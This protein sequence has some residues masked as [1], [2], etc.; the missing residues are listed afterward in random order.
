M[1]WT[2][3][4]CYSEWFLP[5]QCTI[6]N[7]VLWMG[8]LLFLFALTLQFVVGISENPRH[9]EVLI[10]T[11]SLVYVQMPQ[12]LWMREVCLLFI[13][14]EAWE[15]V[16][17][18]LCMICTFVFSM[19][20]PLGF[21]T[22]HLLLVVG[23]IVYY[24]LTH[25]DVAVLANNKNKLTWDSEKFSLLLDCCF[26]FVYCMFYF[27]Q[28]PYVTYIVLFLSALFSL[29]VYFYDEG[30]DRI[31]RISVT[32]VRIGFYL[33]SFFFIYFRV[34]FLFRFL[35]TTLRPRTPPPVAPQQTKDDEEDDEEQ[36]PMKPSPP[37]P[38]PPP[39]IPWSYYLFLLFGVVL[40]CILIGF[41]QTEG[42]VLSYGLL[43]TIASSQLIY[44]NS[45]E[46]IKEGLFFILDVGL[47]WCVQIPLFYTGNSFVWVFIIP[48]IVSFVFFYFEPQVVYVINQ[49]D[50]TVELL[51]RYVAIRGFL[52][53]LVLSFGTFWFI[54]A[55]VLSIFYS[56]ELE[57]IIYRE[58]Y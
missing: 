5:G 13:I 55:C 32:N 37:P 26:T 27:Y 54:T 31:K 36:T 23:V 14:T 22:F 28:T 46:K 7:W 8:V 52:F 11:F 43:L 1:G 15:R 34:G 49:E 6:P 38:P 53:G 33:L 16:L 18:V 45:S 9:F 12:S 20:L 24:F 30:V 4:T 58:I 2:P 21:V 57:R 40:L 51:Q 39:P 56:A 35:A 3:L 48:S 47:F 25:P 44:Y 19:F 17:V 10:K 42:C 50:V 29:L 41:E